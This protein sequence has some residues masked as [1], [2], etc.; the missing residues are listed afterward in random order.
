MKNLMIYISPEGA[1]KT[2]GFHENFDLKEIDESEV[3]EKVA[4]ENSLAMGWKPEDIVLVTNFPY[5]YMG[6][7]ALEVGN[8]NFC[9]H[10]PTASKILAMITLIEK[11]IIGDELW[12]FHDW[13]AFQLEEITEEEVALEDNQLGLTD[14]GVS[15]VNP[16]RSKWWS[17]GSMFLK[18]GCLDILK[19]IMGEADKYQCNEE[20]ALLEMLKKR[21][22][23]RFKPR[24]VKMNITYNLAT[25]RRDI[26]KAYE[27]ADKPLKVIHF[28]PFDWRPT[29]E[30]GNNMEVCIEGKNWLGKPLVTSTLIKLF[31]KHGI[32]L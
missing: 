11:G 19:E 23:Q 9:E 21:R 14:Y 10:S 4:I 29:S 24:I 12:W 8:E 26:R 22:Y 2:T 15:N 28:H 32:I 16:G 13:D 30:G 1:F 27:K 31:K 17:T 20:M 18:Q 6:I 25:R 7:K 3:I 5:E